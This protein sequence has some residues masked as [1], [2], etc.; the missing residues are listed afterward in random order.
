MLVLRSPLTDQVYNNK[1]WSLESLC[2][3]TTTHIWQLRG[4]YALIKT[5]DVHQR[6]IICQTYRKMLCLI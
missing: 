3:S 1:E 6:E 5:F 4:S 2:N